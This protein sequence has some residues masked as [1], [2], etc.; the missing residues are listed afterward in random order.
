MHQNKVDKKVLILQNKILHYRKP[1]YNELSKHY[2]VTILHSGDKS[3]GVNDDYKEIITPV[4]KVGPFFLQSGVLKAVR[5]GGYDVVIAMFDIHWVANI[6]AI[7]LRPNS[8]FLYWGHRYSKNH[9][10]NK[11]RDLLMRLSDGII[12]Y[13]DNEIGKMVSRGIPKSKIFVAPNTIHVP[14]SSDGSGAYKDS[15]LYVGRLQKRKK[16]DL[17]IQAF[18]EILNHIPKNIKI[19]IVGSGQENDTLKKLAEHLGISERVAFHGEIFDSERLKPLFHS[20]YAYVSPGSVGL[21]VLHSFA[22][23]TP[24]VTNCLEKHGPEFNN[25]LNNKN[26]L[27]YKTYDEFKEILV[28]LCNNKNLSRRLGKNAYKLYSQDRTMKKMVQ[29]FRNAIENREEKNNC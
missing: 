24:V 22:Y 1:L 7:F 17:L 25:I 9:L 21:G 20:A 13:T 29:G 10:A 8:R 28:E 2:D 5:S 18:S 16:V 4:K 11:L 14:N 6:I 27:L 12:L 15:F 23:G 19:N 3:A 26:A